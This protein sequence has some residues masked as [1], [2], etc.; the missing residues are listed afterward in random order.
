M[1]GIQRKVIGLVEI[2]HMR[3]HVSGLWWIPENR[4]NDLP[5]KKKG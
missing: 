1:A 5:R 4:D 2:E 3:M